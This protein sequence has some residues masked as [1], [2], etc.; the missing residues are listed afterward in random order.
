[1]RILF[2][3]L[4]ILTSA[5]SGAQTDTSE[6]RLLE[7]PDSTSIGEPDG[8]QVTKLI[9]S[10]G[11]RIASEDRRVE[12]IFP[13]GALVASTTISI[14]P[15][16]NYGPN[17]TGKAYRFGPSGLQ[18]KKPVQVIFHYTDEEAETCPA[19]LMGFAM[20]SEDGKWS[21]M[22]YD[23]WDSTSKKLWGRIHHFSYFTNVWKMRLMPSSKM[24]RVSDTLEM[25]IAGVKGYKKRVVPVVNHSKPLIWFVNNLANGEGGRYGSINSTNYLYDYQRSVPGAEYIAPERLPEKSPV[26]IRLDVLVKDGKKFTTE[27]SFHSK[28]SLYDEYKI[29]VTDTIETRAGEGTFVFDSATFIAWITPKDIEVKDVVNY[30]P[31]SFIKHAAPLFKITVSTEGCIGPVHIGKPK[32]NGNLL[33]YSEKL[34][35]EKSTPEKVLIVFDTQENLAF[36]YSLKG[37]GIRINNESLK[38]E[39]VPNLVS[40]ETSGKEQW[41]RVDGPNDHY[42]INIR[43][44]REPIRIHP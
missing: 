18:F 21:S 8:V 14:Q 16:T 31:G 1:M 36:R 13:A 17:G 34:F 20:Q 26:I 22:D 12:L 30:V 7:L 40:F 6:I 19:D 15:T 39:S 27:R 41:V 9:G 25:Y 32:G 2:V 44:T 3:L 38:M 24:I 29:K 11:G 5:G 10:E 43:R 4:A 28:V 35:I 42:S 37:R 33:S 23:D